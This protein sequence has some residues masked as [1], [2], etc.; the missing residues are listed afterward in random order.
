MTIVEFYKNVLESVGF[1]VTDDGFVKRSKEQ[2]VYLVGGK[3]LVLPTKE[4]INTLT[5]IDESGKAVQTKVLFNPLNENVIK[6]DSESLKIIKKQVEGKLALGI[7]AAGELLIKL[8][9]DI[10]LQAKTSTL[11]NDFLIMLNEANNRNV[12]D[13][14]DD[15]TIEQ[16]VKIVSAIP[17]G[18]EKFIK[19]FA[20]RRGMRDGVTYNR[21]TTVSSPLL[22]KLMSDDKKVDLVGAKLTRQKDIKVYRAVLKYLIPGMD[23]KNTI[24]FGSNSKTSP[25]FIS[26]FE[27]YLTLM[28]RIDKILLELK[29]ITSKTFDMGYTEL[30]VSLEELESLDKFNSELA[31]IPSDTDVSRETYKVNQQSSVQIS[32]TQTVP[33]VVKKEPVSSLPSVNTEETSNGMLKP[34]K[35]PINEPMVPTTHIQMPQNVAQNNTQP[36]TQNNTVQ[37]LQTQSNVNQNTQTVDK[38]RE[39]ANK[40]LYGGMTPMSTTP[41]MNITMP[42]QNPLA[43]VG[44][45]LNGQQPN[46]FNGGV[47]TPQFGNNAMM[48]VSANMNGYGFN[49]QQYNGN[50]MGV[51]QN[52]NS[53]M[54]PKF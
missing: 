9:Y 31:L 2:E 26:I 45:I 7:I 20:K 23:E 47:Q 12:K 37:S 34:Y 50:V 16:Y 35:K 15:K 5:V 11:I 54:Y 10:K 52:I 4:H 33:N 42:Q 30:K 48:G 13:I 8:G 49:Q 40:L 53:G 44:A 1:Y 21:L 24:A 25:G 3:S 28:S 38:T 36:Y 6:G 32:Q 39:M 29:D 43:N 14:I 18:G 51:G 17:K 19:I 22:D 27:T 41:A 46:M